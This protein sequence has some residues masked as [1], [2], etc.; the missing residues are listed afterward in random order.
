MKTLFMLIVSIVFSIGSVIS[1]SDFRLRNNSSRPTVTTQLTKT[2]LPPSTPETNGLFSEEYTDD[3]LDTSDDEE[4]FVL[5]PAPVST[6]MPASENPAAELAPQEDNNLSDEP[7]SESGYD[8]SKPQVEDKFERGS[9][10]FGL[11][12]GLND[13][14]NIR[15]IALNNQLSLIPKK[16]NGWLSWR[17]R[18]PVVQDGAAKM[19]FSITTCARGD[20]FGIAMHANDYTSGNGYYFSLACEGTATILRDNTVLGTADASQF[21]HNNSGDIND[22]TAI[23]RGN[24]LTMELNNETILTVEDSTYAQGFSGFFTSPQGQNTLTMA[25]LSFKE[26]YQ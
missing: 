4:I 16:S 9:A 11:N 13:D 6:A 26:Y 10:G 8:Y 18:P 21:F 20:R 7:A 22:M 17:L 1:P 19:E 23:I 24:T 15:I 3:F 25:I 14:E 2:P 5:R 12:A